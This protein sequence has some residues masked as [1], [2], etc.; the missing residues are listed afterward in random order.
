MGTVSTFLATESVKSAPIERGETKVQIFGKDTKTI[1]NG[2]KKLFVRLR[3]VDKHHLRKS[4]DRKAKNQSGKRNK[5]L[6]DLCF[7][8]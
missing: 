8:I 5:R 2:K 6:P 4:S 3:S 7:L 1:G